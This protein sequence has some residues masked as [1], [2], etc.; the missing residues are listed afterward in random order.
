MLQSISG[1]AL[2]G[3]VAEGATPVICRSAGFSDLLQMLKQVNLAS[4]HPGPT[5]AI[6]DLLG[7]GIVRA[8]DIQGEHVRVLNPDLELI[9][10]ARGDR[11]RLSLLAAKGFGYSSAD[12][13][14]ARFGPALVPLDAMFAPVRRVNYTVSSAR[15]GRRV[16]YDGLMLEVWTNGAIRPDAALAIAA[17]E[18]TRQL[19]V[20]LNFDDREAPQT[21]PL[22]AAEVE[23]QCR[24]ARIRDL[25]GRPLE[26]MELSVRAMNCLLHLGVSSIG[27]L[28]QLNVK[29]LMGV[30]NFGVKSLHE[31]EESL[32]ELGLGLGM[33][34]EGD[35]AL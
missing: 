17:R 21:K 7:P 19:D 35:Q 24:R 10:L 32:G 3:V 16:D 18:M 20:F 23:G 25:C 28:V 13:N 4:A 12:D 6:I 14:L 31:I 11:L 29:Q 34:I 1:T 15:V 2:V 5:R 33:T 9:T 22:P 8:G 27:E 30:R 26:S